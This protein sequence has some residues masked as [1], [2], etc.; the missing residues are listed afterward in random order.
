MEKQKGR[1]VN[2]GLKKYLSEVFRDR[3]RFDEPMSVHTSL[4]IGGPADAYVMPVQ[5]EE[6][7]FLVDRLKKDGVFYCVMGAGTNL[8]VR[9]QGIRGVV[10]S[11]AEGF[12]KIRKAAGGANRV[13]ARSGARLAAVC[14]YALKHSLSGM[15]FALGIP[16]SV[17]GAVTMNAGTGLGSMA[18]VVENLRMLFDD[19]VAMSLDKSRIQW[20]YRGFAIARP[21]RDKSGEGIILE[22]EFLLCPADPNLLKK[23]AH[24]LIQKRKTT[25]PW[26]AA[27]AGCFFKNPDSGDSAG[28]LIDSAGLKGFRVGDAEVSK[29]HAN[30]IVNR[31][32]ASADDILR[33]M[34]AVQERVY[35]NFNLKLEPEVKIVG[36]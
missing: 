2:P 30:F 3:V 26:R 4:K 35:K 36:Q 32:H 34:E 22:A 25:Q 18:G 23:E 31:G 24:S 13:V 14:R 12:T 9:D 29:K 17:G 8:L 21:G 5:E 27:S 16:G 15:N 10:I 7:V 33:L 20:S 11:L 6:L 1:A 19:G 28:R